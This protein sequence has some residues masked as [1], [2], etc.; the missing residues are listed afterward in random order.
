MTSG[1]EKGYRPDAVE[2]FLLRV[3]ETY[4]G[5]LKPEEAVRAFEIRQVA[6]PLVRKGYHPRYVDAA[7]DR[8]EEVLFER[9]RQAYIRDHGEDGWSDL[10]N[11]LKEEILGRVAR[12]R[13]KRFRRRSPFAHGYRRSQVDAV[14]DQL[15]EVIASQGQV[16]PQDIRLL[17][18][19]SQ[20]RGYEESQVDAFFDSVIEYILAQR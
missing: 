3:R 20:R 12:P 2:T 7:L 9:E 6:F 18:F 4:E 5:R 14:L 15:G 19:H 1:R 17:R 10:V 16:K 8:L 11:E 13:G